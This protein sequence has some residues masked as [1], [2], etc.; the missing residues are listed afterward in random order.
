MRRASDVVKLDRNVSRGGFRNETV[1]GR[2]QTRRILARARYEDRRQLVRVQLDLFHRREL[3]PLRRYRRPYVE[4]RIEAHQT[5]D[6][7]LRVAMPMA[8]SGPPAE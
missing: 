4:H 7:R 6:V 2:I 5:S 3:R 8:S 1:D